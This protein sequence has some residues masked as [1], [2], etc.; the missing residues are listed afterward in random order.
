MTLPKN[1]RALFPCWLLHWPCPEH[2]L[3]LSFHQI[4]LSSRFPTRIRPSTHCPINCRE[5]QLSPLVVFPKS[6]STSLR[7]KDPPL[8]CSREMPARLPPSQA[9]PR[10]PSELGFG[11][12]GGEFWLHHLC[13]L[14]LFRM[15]LL[16]LRCLSIWPHRQ[17]LHA[18][19]TVAE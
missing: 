12:F 4:I 9:P 16:L 15:Q 19:A 7:G 3:L 5:T 2:L 10:P 13:S 14:C 18:G 1:H 11:E 8:C 17:G 6:L